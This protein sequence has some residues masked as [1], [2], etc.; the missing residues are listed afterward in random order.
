MDKN[1]PPLSEPEVIQHLK[2]SGSLASKDNFEVYH[3]SYIARLSEAL[4][5]TYQAVRWVLGKD[6]FAELC[7]RFIESQPTV[8]YHLD[9]YGREM[10]D[11]M[12]IH[13]TSKHI[14]FLYD[15]ARFE[16]IYKNLDHAPNPHPLPSEKVEEL[17]GAEDF[18]I[19]FIKEMEIFDSPYSIYDLWRERQGPSYLF[20]DINWNHPESLLIYKK[21]KK[22]HVTRIDRIEAQVLNE[23]REGISVAS[24]LADYSNSLSPDKVAQLFKLLGK[25]G[26]I[27]NILV[28]E[29]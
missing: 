27:E 5:G 1:P 17:L 9:L 7:R 14:S 23:L 18:K 26:V 21:Q 20:E 8:P 12:R 19:R 3:Q 13:P 4:D 6:L 16:W 29:S 24:A 25:A 22:I 11:F 28:T 10:A 15:L 2:P